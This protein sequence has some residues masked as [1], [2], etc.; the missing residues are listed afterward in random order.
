MQEEAEREDAD[1][2]HKKNCSFKLQVLLQQRID[3][4][5]ALNELFE[6][7]RSGNSIIKTYKQMKMYN[8]P[9]LNPILRKAK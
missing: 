7:I 3:L 9:K 1:E 6:N 8:D 2:E 5:Q 4:S